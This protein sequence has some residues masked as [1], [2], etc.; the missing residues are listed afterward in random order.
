MI[1]LGVFF[2]L[3]GGRLGPAL[4]LL[5]LAVFTLVSWHIYGSGFE[6]ILGTGY[7]MA[8]AGFVAGLILAGGEYL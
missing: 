2:G 1:V 4:G 7:L 5:G 3:R 6:K 8:L